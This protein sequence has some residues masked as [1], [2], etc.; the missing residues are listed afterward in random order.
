[1]NLVRER[2]RICEYTSGDLQS[3]Y[4]GTSYK[5]YWG[6]IAAVFPCGFIDVDDYIILAYGRQDRELWIAKIDKKGLYES[7][8]SVK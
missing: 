7:L 1:M 6:S 5:P 8:V 3:F 4:H 2:D